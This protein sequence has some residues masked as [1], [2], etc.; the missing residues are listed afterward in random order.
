M[1]GSHMFLSRLP[2]LSSLPPTQALH[3]PASPEEPQIPLGQHCDLIELELYYLT[4]VGF[5][6]QQRRTN[7]L[8]FEGVC[9]AR[10]VSM[11]LSA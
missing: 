1:S 6:R 8:L 5:D 9:S 10:P 7:A 2:G 4:P 3:I 11:S